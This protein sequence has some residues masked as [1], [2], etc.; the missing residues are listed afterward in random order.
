LETVQNWFKRAFVGLHAT[1]STLA[2]QELK[3][4]S[5]LQP[6]LSIIYRCSQDASQ[7]LGSCW[8]SRHPT[9]PSSDNI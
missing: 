6:V 2:F 1:D 3:H 4:M 5:Y 8:P 7:M 9:A